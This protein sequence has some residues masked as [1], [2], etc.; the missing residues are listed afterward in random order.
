MKV[1]RLWSSGRQH[2]VAL[3]MT[4]NILEGP[5]ASIF[6]YT[7]DGGTRFLQNPG[8]NLPDYSSVS[9][10]MGWMPGVQFLSGERF[11]SSPQ[12]PEAY[13]VSYPMRT[14]E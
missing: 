10:A 6:S 5:T 9:T 12:H 3:S 13:P 1:L 14:T 2:C 8:N 11:F 4:T 7:E